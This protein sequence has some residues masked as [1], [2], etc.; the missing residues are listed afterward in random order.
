LAL[1]DKSGVPRLVYSA[2]V[3][4]LP[5]GKTITPNLEWDPSSSTLSVPLPEP[6]FP[7]VIV[8]G[9]GLKVPDVHGG[10]HLAL[11][12]IKFGAKGEIEDSSSSDSDDEGKRKL[13]I[14]IKAPKFG[15]G[16]G[17][18]DK[19]AEIDVAV[20]ASGSTGGKLKVLLLFV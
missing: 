19:S 10:F 17:H 12:S 15:F 7:L 4:R 20:E 13:G 2:P 16:L 8:F 1:L 9:L 3:F 14:D 11:P 5:A 18:K 6:S